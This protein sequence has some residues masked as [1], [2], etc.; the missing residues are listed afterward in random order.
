MIISRSIR[1]AATGIISFILWLSNILYIIFTSSS[2][3]GHLGCFHV[4]A[5]INSAAI[6]H[7]D[8]SFPLN[9][10]GDM[11]RSWIAG[12]YGSSILVFYGTCILVFIVTVPIYNP[13]DSVRG[14]PF[15][16]ALSSNYCL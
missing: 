7:W 1:V 14:F 13:I 4:L 5:I 6:E 16:Q 12:S 11:P 3:D 2:F 10:F 9:I 8:A 15:L